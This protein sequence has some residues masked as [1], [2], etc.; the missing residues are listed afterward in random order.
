MV[1]SFFRFLFK[2]RLDIERSD[3]TDTVQCFIE[4]VVHW[5]TGLRLDPLKL[6]G[7]R[8]IIVLKMDLL[9]FM[10]MQVIYNKCL[11]DYSELMKV[12]SIVTIP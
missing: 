5:G 8:A 6:A 2:S 3:N 1:Y 7:G 11:S 10:K 9:Y 4:V 12:V